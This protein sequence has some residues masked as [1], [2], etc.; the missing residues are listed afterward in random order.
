MKA[1]ERKSEVFFTSAGTAWEKVDNGIER[2]FVGY[3]DRI[4]MVKVKFEKGAVGYVHNH[5]HS[6]ATYVASGVFKITVEGKDKILREGDGFFIASNVPHGAECL[7][8]GMLIDVFSPARE[9]FLK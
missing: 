8:D 3:D 9:D 2:Q 5:Y 7:E 4:M 1:S 6:Q